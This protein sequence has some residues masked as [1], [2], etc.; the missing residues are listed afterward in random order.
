MFYIRLP[1]IWLSIIFA[2]LGVGQ[3][4]DFTLSI[5]SVLE[6]SGFL[7]F[8]MPRFSLKAR[9]KPRLET[10]VNRAELFWDTDSGRPIMQGMGQVFYLRTGD[11][12]TPE[13]QKAQRFVDWLASDIGLRTIEQFTI[14]GAQVFSI[15]KIEIIAKTEAVFTGDV[16]RGE[17]L[18]F[19]N[20][21]RCHVIGKRNLMKGI[22]ST[23]SFGLLRGLPDWQERFMTFYLRP[24]HPAIT[25]IKDITEPFDPVHPPTIKALALTESELEDILTFAASVEPV[26]LGVPLI[27]H[28]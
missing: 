4:Q 13:G 17:A 23:P 18:S 15:V 8:I 1:A 10:N 20:C 7:Q 26:D 12:K 22:G 24:P 27:E 16:V 25:Q 21:A 2:S 11:L 9:I 5:D 6:D 14:D 3:A 19:T 28:Q